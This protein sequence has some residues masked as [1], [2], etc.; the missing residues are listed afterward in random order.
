M[1][2]KKTIWILIPLLIA[3]TSFAKSTGGGNGGDVFICEDPSQNV[4]LDFY[5]GKEKGMFENF[6]DPSK[7]LTENYLKWISL[8]NMP[9][10][11]Q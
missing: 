6:G 10:P 7:S 5:E 4:I 11:M 8:L 3:S 9:N 1:K 2:R